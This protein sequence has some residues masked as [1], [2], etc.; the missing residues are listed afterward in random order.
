MNMQVF[1]HVSCA[2]HPG[3]HTPWAKRDICTLAHFARASRR[4]SHYLHNLPMIGRCVSRHTQ[5]CPQPCSVPSRST[6][7]CVGGLFADKATEIVLRVAPELAYRA[8]S[9]PQRLVARLCGEPCFVDRQHPAFI[10]CLVEG[11]CKPCPPPPT[12]L[13]GGLAGAHQ[14]FGRTCVESARGSSPQSVSV[15][16]THDR[17]RIVCCVKAS[18]QRRLLQQHAMPAQDRMQ[19]DHHLGRSSGA[20]LDGRCRLCCV[21]CGFAPLVRVVH[22]RS[23]GIVILGCSEFNRNRIGGRLAANPPASSCVVPPGTFARSCLFC[24]LWLWRAGGGALPNQRNC[25]YYRANPSQ[26]GNVY[27]TQIC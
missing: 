18:W 11:K 22:L 27:R 10:R 21:C 25:G 2:G 17:G 3:M 26:G 4:H 20:D 6:N 16:W 23:V 19:G 5:Q 24:A 1:Q 12:F 7:M 15:V 14:S 8:P 13:G 9:C